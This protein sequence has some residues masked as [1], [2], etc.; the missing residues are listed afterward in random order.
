MHAPITRRDWLTSALAAGTLSGW[1]GRVAAQAAEQPATSPKSCILLWMSGGPSHLDTFDLK[2]EARDNIRGEF[3]PIDTPVAGIQI[4]E[5]FPRFA[6]Q[7]E[8]AAIFRG[9]STVES[10]HQLATYHMHTGY[11]KRAGG[12][13]F[14]SLGAIVSRELGKKDVPVPN[15]VCIGA[16][17]R[18]ATRSGLLG[19]D[20]QPLD[21]TDPDRGLDFIAPLAVR[22][23]F[24]RQFDLLRR[25]DASFHA[26]YRSDA[27]AAH[28]SA[29]DRAVRLMNAEQKQAFDLSHEPDDVRERYGRG[30]FGQGCL[31]A[32]RLVE[33]GVRF[34]EVLSGGGVGWDTHRDNF[35]RTKSLS[36]EADAGMAALID[37]LRERGLLED[38]LV[39]WMGEF[40]RSPQT[41]S[42]GGRNHWA[43]AWSSVLAGGGIRGGQV[44]GRTD[45][46][47]AAVVERPISVTDF[48]GTICTILGIDYTR[49]NTAPGVA[50]PIPIVDTS[51][52]VKLVSEVL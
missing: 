44:V 13:A 28:A 29:V 14:P 52:Q 10:D 50:R 6:Q 12:I 8:H 47:A 45:R 2:P 20:H 16:G 46:D 31:M 4:S 11:Q 37:D 24:D 34:V 7:L 30:S 5:H 1:L 27:G 49:N 43:A 15:F 19:P 40:G 23:E 21:V 25:F 3:R 48:L 18:L 32:R 22:A 26:N 39:I 51:K 33:T 41:T 36:L 9:M 35:P 17:P 42:G 38:T